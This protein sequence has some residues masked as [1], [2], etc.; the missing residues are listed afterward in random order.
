MKPYRWISAFLVMIMLLTACAPKGEEVPQDTVI[1][2]GRPTTSVVIATGS[3]A[4]TTTDTTEASATHSAT[5]N[6][7]RTT[8][9]S[10]KTTQGKV[11]T[12]TTTKVTTV[13]TAPTVPRQSLN[14]EMRAAWVSY[15]EV[16]ELLNGC[17]TVEQACA[18]IDSLMD[19]LVSLRMNT[20]FFH[21]RANSDAYYASSIF[22]P[23]PAVSNL[24]ANGFDPLGYAV[25]AAHRKGLQLHAWIN[26]YRVG[27]KKE[28]LV[29]DV[30]TLTDKSNRYYYV[31]TS[32]A[33]Q[34]LILNGVREVLNNYAVDGIQYD[35]YFYPDSLLKETTV[36]SYESADYDAYRKAGGVLPIADWRRAGVDELIAATH[37]LTAAKGVVFGV[38]PA[39]SAENTYK[40]L[41]AD[42]RKWL[43]EEGYVDYLCPQLY[44]GFENTSSPFNT[45]VDTWMS[46]PRH[47]SVELYVG[48]ALYK[49]GLK[50]DAYAGNGKTEWLKNN[51]I[52]KR[53]TEY[54]R[55]KK[56]TG[57]CF[58]SYSYFDPENKTGLSET[59]DVDVAKQ[60][61]KHLLDVL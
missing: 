46:Y 50:S 12:T 33:A 47:S 20:V 34:T 10:T 53:E 19:K 37:T 26:P 45:L 2:V 21:V 58:Y 54:L 7:T 24:I 29:G 36:Y 17:K 27:T 6:G 38:S 57:L 14:G 30:P 15:I 52:I 25:E 18:A 59:N 8:T 31:P 42:C 35:D 5:E 23:A 32:K 1:T 44:T 56:I 9:T 39:A 11:R 3:S 16:A 48:M 61:I 28:Y 4:E 60:E 22:K 55:Q 13:T 51:D 40:Y 43:A 41:Y 49:I